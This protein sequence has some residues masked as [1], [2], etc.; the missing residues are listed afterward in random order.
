MTKKVQK[1]QRASL[2]NPVRVEVANKYSTVDKLHQSYIFIPQKFK[3]NYLVYILNE[4]AGNS[5][6]IFCCTCANT[7]RIAIILRNLGLNA[8]PLHGQMSQNKR[9]G[10]LN[11]FKSKDYSIIVSKAYF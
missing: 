7:T 3:E 9:L 10:S 4:L 8:I 2:Q 6:M 11:K 1:L 5:F